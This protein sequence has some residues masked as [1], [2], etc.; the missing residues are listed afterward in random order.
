MQGVGNHTMA[1]TNLLFTQINLQ[2]CKEASS[3]MSHIINK[4]LTSVAL[5]QEPWVFKK[6]IRGLNTK[7]G[8]LFCNSRCDRR[9]TCIVSGAS[10]Q[11]RLLGQFTSQDLTAI[12]TTID[13]G[14]QKREL[15]I[16]SAYLPYDAIT[17]PPSKELVSH[18]FCSTS[19]LPLIIG[20]DANSHHHASPLLGE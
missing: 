19:K 8:Q 6:Y 5:F 3:L 4:K 18:S 1:T 20:C 9:R 11:A 13:M 15:V 16:G 10:V 2:H 14:G 7:G 17:P 12:Q